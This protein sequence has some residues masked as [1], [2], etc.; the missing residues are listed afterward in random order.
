M[1]TVATST[2][3]YDSWISPSLVNTSEQLIVI[4]QLCIQYSLNRQDNV[5]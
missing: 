3:N 5:S 2:G 4:V 1:Y